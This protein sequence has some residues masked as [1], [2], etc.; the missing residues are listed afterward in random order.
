MKIIVGKNIH[1]VVIFILLISIMGF[2][3]GF[4]ISPYFKIQE[5]AR[6]LPRPQRHP[7]VV[8]TQTDL[9]A[10]YDMNQSLNSRIDGL[11]SQYFDEN[12]FVLPS[13]ITTYINNWT[14]QGNVDPTTKE[15]LNDICYYLLTNVMPNI[16]TKD[17]PAPTI[18]WPKIKWT[19]DGWFPLTDVAN[20]W[21]YFGYSNSPN[22]RDF[23]LNQ[24]YGST[25]T[26]TKTNES[27]STTTTT[28]NTSEGSEND[29]YCG[30]NG[31]PQ[32]GNLCPTSCFA[33]A[34]M[35][36]TESE[37]GSE[38]IHATNVGIGNEN[39]GSNSPA[40]QSIAQQKSGTSSKYYGNSKIVIVTTN[41]P[42]TN[43]TIPSPLD[44]SLNSLI[45]QYFDVNS[46]FPTPY[47]INMFNKYVNN[48]EPVDLLH[49]NKLRDVIYYFMENIIPGL[50]T[51]TRPVSY[52]EWIPIRWLSHSS[53]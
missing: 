15:K 36:N 27:T 46:G 42:Q 44:S 29:Q 22:Y 30:N 26:S 50:P 51:N 14:N 34:F 47:A 17:I 43:T 1:I 25:S 41:I 53:I 13:T 11:I 7:V 18:N 21:T 45:E 23:H 3:F 35:K 38:L 6:T 31:M 10:V 19:S 48:A 33:N 16:P 4:Y 37:Y 28:T 5:G 9:L 20:V 32:C 39:T 2:I 49:K 8:N 40:C 24:S 52:V 12:N